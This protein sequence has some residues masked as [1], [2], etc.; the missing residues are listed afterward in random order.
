MM[1]FKTGCGGRGRS[2]FISR[3]E[4][5]RKKERKKERMEM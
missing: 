5:E 3:M 4:K 1:D 2:I